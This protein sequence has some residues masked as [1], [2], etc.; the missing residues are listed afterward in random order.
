MVRGH[1]CPALTAPDLAA[2]EQDSSQTN[3]I[4][5]ADPDV[6]ERGPDLPSH[7]PAR[8]HPLTPSIVSY[9]T[10]LPVRPETRAADL[11]VW[12]GGSTTL[13][14]RLLDREG[15]RGTSAAPRRPVGPTRAQRGRGSSWSASPAKGVERARVGA[16]AGVEPDHPC[17][18]DP[19]PGRAGLTRLGRCPTGLAQVDVV[20]GVGAVVHESR[21][22]SCG[23]CG[24]RTRSGA[25]WKEW[26]PLPGPSFAPAEVV[27][28]PAREVYARTRLTRNRRGRWLLHRRAGRGGQ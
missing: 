18:P 16:R 25:V 7:P 23:G 20:A 22:A 27:V 6:D 26:R 4:R 24:R 28:R 14:A 12:P 15:C 21:R 1:A 11:A 9:R 17:R 10:P 8:L 19:Q 3:G 5:P 2:V 13:R